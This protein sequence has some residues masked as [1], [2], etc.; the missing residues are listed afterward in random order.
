[1][2]HAVT[3]GCLCGAVRYSA[4][5]PDHD[6]CVCWCSQCRRQCSGP[7]VSL[8]PAV[9]WAV[10]GEAATFRASDHAS[11]GFCAACVSTLFWQGDGEGPSF[12][13][14]S[15]DHR[16]GYRIARVVHA[17]GRPDA[18]DLEALR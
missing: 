6:L 7:L 16:D 11:R 18:Y 2:S 9:E 10:E 13:L 4:V 8:S 15:L 17:D 1:M 12:T 5:L 14:G 3:G